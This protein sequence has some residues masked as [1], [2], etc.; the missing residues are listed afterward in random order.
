MSEQ[1]NNHGLKGGEF[2]T[3]ETDPLYVFTPEDISEDQRMMADTAK[4]FI[5]K[6]ILPK[7]DAIDNQEP[8]LTVKLME[9]A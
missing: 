9:Q 1:K 3:K 4:D 6:E 7:L 8:G 5:E 2:L